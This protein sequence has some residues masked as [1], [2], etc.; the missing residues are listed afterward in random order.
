VSATTPMERIHSARQSV[1]HAVETWDGMDVERVNRCRALLEDSV[2]E[3]KAAAASAA[4]GHAAIPAAARRELAD[5]KR[6]VGTMIRVVDAC[7]AFQRGLALRSGRA[8]P[9]YDASGLT[10]RDEANPA[11]RV[12]LDV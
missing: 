4:G 5:L 8:D 1:R 6:D 12:V 7:S 10:P 11:Q 2:A 3:L 9:N